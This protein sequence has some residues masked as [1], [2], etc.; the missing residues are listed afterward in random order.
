MPREI[1]RKFLVS[2][3]G[4]RTTGSGER[5]RQGYLSVEPGRTVRVRVRGNRAWLTVKGRT[6]GLA[7]QEYEYPIPLTDANEML[8]GLCEQPILDKTRHVVPHGGH[9]WEIDVFHGPNDGLVMA[10]LEL[11]DE[12]ESF[13]RPS[14]LGA[15]VSDDPR[16]FN[17]NLVRH[18]FN[19][20]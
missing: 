20:W 12:N 14:W 2:G 3:A 5:I 15:E 19:R 9:T 8:D 10:E 13:E 1:E 6:S 11:K 7:R 18:P 17:S 16:Y 4:W